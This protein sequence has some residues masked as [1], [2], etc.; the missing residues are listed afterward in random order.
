MK[1][2]LLIIL[3]LV[4]VI[5]GGLLGYG[6]WIMSS[7]DKIIAETYDIEGMDVEIPM[8]SLSLARGYHL[9]VTRG[10]IGC[11][12]DNLA[13]ETMEDMGPVGIFHA[14]NLTSGEGGIGSSYT[15]RDWERAI[16]HG[17][18][19]SGSHTFMMPSEEYYYLSDS[20]LGCLI[21]Y[22]QTVEPVDKQMAESEIGSV[23]KVMI[24]TGQ[25]TILTP[26]K[27][28]PHDAPRP[29]APPVGVTVAYG[30]YIGHTCTG[31]HGVN[32]AGGIN[33]GPD[34][35]V[36]TN[37]TPSGMADYD[38]DSFF[39]AMRDGIRPNGDYIDPFMP[40]IEYSQMTDDELDALWLYLQSLPS[41]ENEF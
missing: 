17:V 21:A 9:S 8:D 36:T 37:L 10:C 19:P 2:V 7:A 14:S 29:M 15:V 26:A 31:C 30:E 20:D 16:R 27:Y 24:A 13:G 35:P 5:V 18:K 22:L 25:M 4:V 41:V 39:D 1:K 32:L 28:I 34:I 23:G 33:I 12:G 3:I 11:H 6:A 40:F 38:R